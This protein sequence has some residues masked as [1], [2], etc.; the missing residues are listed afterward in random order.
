MDP[1]KDILSEADY[2]LY[3]TNHISTLKRHA[4]KYI[5]MENENGEDDGNKRADN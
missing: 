1:K 3:R 2:M 4:E 5:E